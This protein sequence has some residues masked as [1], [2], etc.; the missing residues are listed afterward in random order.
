MSSKQNAEELFEVIGKDP[1]SW[2]SQAQEMKTVADT[3]LPL[4]QR[5]LTIPPTF[6]ETQ[7]K[8]LAYVGSYMLFIGLAFENLIKGIL[9]G[10]NPTLVTREKIE[11]GI[12]GRNGHGIA[13]GASRI[14]RLR[15]QEFQL[16]ERVEEY[17]FWAGRYPLPLKSNSFINSEK[18][19]LRTFRSNDPS[20]IDKLFK[21]IVEVFEN[22]NR[23]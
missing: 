22:E 15:Q 6:P 3:I 4:L 13:E 1:F 16:L 18:R 2:L 7:R 9:I 5:E 19:K 20:M 23:R 17:L 11:S 21:K 8:R 14:I 12:L 10:Q